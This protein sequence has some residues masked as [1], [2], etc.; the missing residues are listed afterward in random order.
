MKNGISVFSLLATVALFA[1]S[2][3][4]GEKTIAAM[5]KKCDE[6]KIK[7]LIGDALIKA[8][9]NPSGMEGIYNITFDDTKTDAQKLMMKLVEAKCIE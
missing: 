3:Q 9:K 7:E 8:E 4:A 1:S 5:S 2:A 6:A